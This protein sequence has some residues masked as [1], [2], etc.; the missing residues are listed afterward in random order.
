MNG[1]IGGLACS[2]FFALPIPLPPDEDRQRMLAKVAELMAL[3]D[4]LKAQRQG[5]ETQPLRGCPRVPG[6]RGV[7]DDGFRV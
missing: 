5:R 4:R 6:D 3:C 2:E 7:V 1:T